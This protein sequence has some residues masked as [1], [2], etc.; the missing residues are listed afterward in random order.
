MMYD[1]DVEGV[2]YPVDAENENDAWAKAYTQHQAAKAMPEGSV[3]AQPETTAKGVMGAAIRGGGPVAAGAGIGAILGGAP[4]GGIGA[5]PGAAIGAMVVPATTFIGDPLI[6]GLNE[7]LG[8]NYE[9][10][11][12]TIDA[13]LTRLGVPEAKTEAERIVQTA[14]QAGAGAAGSAALFNQIA[15]VAPQLST[16]QASAQQMAAQPVQQAVGGAAA[17]ASGQYAAEEGA[18]PVVQL[19]ASLGGGLAGSMAAPRMPEQPRVMVPSVKPPQPEAPTIRGDLP[20][21]P[22]ATE[23]QSA[24]FGDLVRLAVRG[25]TKAR[26]SVAELAAINPEAK[27]AAEKLGLELPPDVLS[28]YRLLKETTA[29]AR[30]IKQS[31]QSVAWAELVTGVRKRADEV[32]AQ[33]DANSDMSVV[34]SGIHDS[35]ASTRDDMEKAARIIYKGIDDQLPKATPANLKNTQQ[36]LSDTMRDLG[37][38]E[39]LTTE[40]KRLLSMAT[41]PNTTYGALLREKSAIGEKLA[42]KGEGYPNLDKATLSKLY[43]ALSDDQIDAVGARLGDEG[44]ASLREANKLTAQRKVMERKIVGMYGKDGEGS[45]ASKL[46][47]AIRSGGSKGDVTALYKVLKI[48]PKPLQKEALSSAILA[49]SRTPDGA[50]SFA[51]FATLYRGLRE[52]SQVYVPIGDALGKEGAELMRSLYVVSRRMNAAEQMIDKTGKANQALFNS[53]IAEGITAK[54]VGSPVGRAAATVAAVKSGVPIGGALASSATDA[55]TRNNSK[56]LDATSKFLTSTEFE[57]LIRNA[58][59]KG[60]KDALTERSIRNTVRSQAFNAYAT[61]RG[62]AKEPAERER[63]L[64]NVVQSS[65]AIEEPSE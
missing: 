57:N 23:S 6:T 35:L 18:G 29:A 28:D 2:T 46:Q 36:V 53:L 47:A 64:R 62:I 1:V 43:G 58:A 19:L 5:L 38:V 37:G 54:I 42:G 3:T 34:S 26:E 14:A 59:A 10:P 13:L 20:E 31:P 41:D 39:K 15:K 48:V 21:M 45:I 63:W 24:Q 27:L 8:T 7:W 9:T 30:G 32:M 65:A 51:K 55:I 22:V 12:Q 17:G 4:T 16:L 60:A 40:E 52:N 25:N 11:T 33:L 44:V 49:Q 56:A 50:F 61:A